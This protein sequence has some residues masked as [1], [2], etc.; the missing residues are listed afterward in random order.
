MDPECLQASHLAM[1]ASHIET[2]DSD[3]TLNRVPGTGKIW[4]QNEHVE[5]SLS[6]IDRS[7]ESLQRFANFSTQGVQMLITPDVLQKLQSSS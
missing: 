1:Q 7:D 6:L 2:P 4:V 3:T 5:L